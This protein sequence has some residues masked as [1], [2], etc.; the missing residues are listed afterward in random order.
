[1]K[2]R[3]EVKFG[4]RPQGYQPLP[5]MGMIDPTR[6]LE[7]AQAGLDLI[8]RLLRIDLS[9]EQSP[10]TEGGATAGSQ[11]SPEVRASLAA[12][13]ALTGNATAYPTMQV[14]DSG[15]GS[16]DPLGYVINQEGL[17]AFNALWSRNEPYRPNTPALPQAVAT[18]P[19]PSSPP[20]MLSINHPHAV[21]IG[22]NEGTRTKDGGFTN[23]YTS[24]QDPLSGN[25]QGNF[26][27]QQGYSSPREADRAWLSKLNSAS[28]A[29]FQPSMK[30]V[31][32]Q[33]GTAGW[34]RVL[35]NLRDAY[36]QSPASVTAS[37][38]LLDRLPEIMQGG[39]TV[40]AIARAR[41][42]SYIN[43]RTKRLD[44]NFRSYAALLKDQRSRA[45]TWDYKRRIGN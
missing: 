21:L 40:E 4:D 27:A 25:N 29:Y 11:Y 10:S 9:Q 34:E 22:L 16:A 14:T 37:G 36:V 1:M 2:N 24:H 12:I 31:G 39:A 44:T 18:K 19:V 45:G 26:S 6:A 3:P 8:Q 38:G 17:P 33:P 42:N 28:F 23:A 20:T 13:A 35:F 30:A 43:P 41:A 15:E 32:L 5:R 7:G